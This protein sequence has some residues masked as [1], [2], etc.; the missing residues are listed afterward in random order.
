VKPLCIIPVYLRSDRDLHLTNQAIKTLKETSDADLL[1]IDDGS[2]SAKHVGALSALLPQ[3]EL[4]VK[5]DNGGFSTAVNIGLE[6]ALREERDAVLVNADVEFIEPMSY[7]WLEEFQRTE[8]SVV[9][10]KLL[11]PNNIVQH[12]GVYYSILHRT[13]EHI[14]RCS[15]SGLPELNIPRRCPVTGALMFIRYETLQSVGV[16]DERFRMGYEDVDYCC[17]VIKSGRMC[18][19][20]P[21]I[22]A[23]HHEKQFRFQDEQMMGMWWQRSWDYFN[24]KWEGQDVGQFMPFMRDTH[25]GLHIT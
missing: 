22:V 15:P 4:F 18:L 24:E 16:L 6:R 21:K 13:F 17:R 14:G 8:A 11:Y 10:A 3:G 1:V 25:E 12:A 5:P 7:G 20:N 23:I 9:G 19:Y 2:P